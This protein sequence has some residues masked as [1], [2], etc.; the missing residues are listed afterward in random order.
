M[1]HG[2]FVGVPSWPGEFVESIWAGGNASIKAQS[3]YRN[4]LDQ[5]ATLHSLY[6]EKC[7]T[8]RCMQCTIRVAPVAPAIKRPGGRVVRVAGIFSARMQGACNRINVILP[9]SNHRN[10]HQQQQPT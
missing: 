8:G 4:S 1:G 10:A 2:S 5:D 7:L 9:S 6:P 3:V